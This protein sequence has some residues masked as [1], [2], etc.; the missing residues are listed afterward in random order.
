M[1]RFATLLSVA[2]FAAALFA[3][4]ANVY[5][6]DEETT[7]TVKSVKEADKSKAKAEPKTA[8]EK[9]AAAKKRKAKV[10]TSVSGDKTPKGVKAAGNAN[11]PVSGAPVGSMQAGSH[12]VY[13]GYKVGLCCDGC[14][15]RFNSNPDSYLNAALGR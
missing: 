14:K 4:P 3:Q 1:K 12:I 7:Q 11:C 6:Q 2:M 15:G 9:R 10:D 13:K 8:K 5:A